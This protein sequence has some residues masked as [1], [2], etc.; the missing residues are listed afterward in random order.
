MKKLILLAA[1]GSMSFGAAAQSQ[2][3]YTFTDTRTIAQTPVKD[4]ASSGTCWSFAGLGFIESELLKQGK[5]EHDLSEMWV[6]RNTYFEKA[7]NYARMHGHTNLGAGGVGHDVFNAIDKYG[8]VP[9][10]V[11]SG[12][13]YGTDE[14]RHGEL[15]SA[16]KGYMD[17][18]I[19]NRNRQLSEGWEKGLNGIL[20]AYFGVM[21]TEFTYKGK[22]YT[23]KSFA[24]ELGIKGEDYVSVTSFTHHPY[25]T[26]FVL[27]VPDNWAWGD[28][29]NV[30][31]DEF[32]AIIDR[33]LEN[34][35]SVLWSSD[36]SERGF[37]YNDG[38]AI[39]PISNITDMADSEKA[40]WSTL[41]QAELGSRDISSAL[42]EIEVT[43]ENRQE[44]FDNYTTTDD[45]AMVITGEAKAQN[46]DKFYKV[47]NSWAAENIY[48][49]YFYASVPFVL[50][51]T[52][53]IMV[54]KSMLK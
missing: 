19:K 44:G 6:V 11:Y 18:I 1:I 24:K 4:Q 29:I 23:P 34:G 48:G 39:L 35:H 53:T 32:K 27:E 46:G 54:P 49:G 14:H 17:A 9:E 41:T 8:I 33:T 10:E 13:Q 21:P 42:P 40:R 51:K 43:A 25:G 12:L 38:F 16:I 20:D 3:A 5:G 37:K 2:K 15:D 30:T 31:M 26:S 36:V 50:A 7:K 45:H 22:K 47:K 28:V 52:T